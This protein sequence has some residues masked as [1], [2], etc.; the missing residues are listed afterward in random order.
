MNPTQNQLSQNPSGWEVINVT[1]ITV[2]I[3]FNVS[4]ITTIII[5]FTIIVIIITFV[6]IIFTNFTIILVRT[7]VDYLPRPRP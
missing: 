6:I 2:S 5:I 4:I 7:P 3:I 1:I